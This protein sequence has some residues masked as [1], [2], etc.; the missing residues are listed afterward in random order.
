MVESGQ[1]KIKPVDFYSRRHPLLPVEVVERRELIKRVDP[2]RFASPQRPS[3]EALMLM[4]SAQGSHTIDFTEI[5]TRPGR[6]LRIRPGQIQAWHT[7][8]DF[9]AT[10]VLSQP[11]IATTNPWFPGDGSYCDLDVDGAASAEGIID[12]LRRQQARFTGDEPSRRLMI[13]LF[14]ALVAVFDQAQITANSHQLP[15][16]YVAF[17]DAIE[18]D[19]SHSHGVV[20][21]ARALGYSARTITRACQKATGQTAKQ[22][23][24]DRLVL[25]AKRLLVHTDIPAATISAQLGF[26]EPTNFTKFFTRNADQTPSAFRR[27]DRHPSEAGAPV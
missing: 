2:E 5:P 26:S 23:L 17:R 16:A 13:A 6:L 9:D 24:T 22:I 8:V 3:F 27:L 19:L 18:S 7:D 10:L 4:R 20:D 1:Q 14:D 12:A 15:E 21:Y 11:A 25:E